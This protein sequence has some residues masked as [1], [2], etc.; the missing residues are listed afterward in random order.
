MYWMGEEKV[1]PQT[2]SMKVIG[3]SFLS[4]MT[5]NIWY[6]QEGN[7]HEFHKSFAIRK[8]FLLENNLLATV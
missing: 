7:F 3:E 5:P 1:N 2:V 8:N 4:R 6:F